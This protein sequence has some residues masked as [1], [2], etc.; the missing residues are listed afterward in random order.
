MNGTNSTHYSTLIRMA[1]L[2]MVFFTATYT[3]VEAQSCACK[4]AIQVSVDA[5]CDI[6][7]STADVLTSA[8]T[9]AGGSTITLMKTKT[10]GVI[11]DE[12]T[13]PL[14]ATIDA[15]LLIGKTIYAKVTA[16]GELNSCW[17][18]V[19]IE[20]KLKPTWW[21]TIPDTCVVTC[22]TCWQ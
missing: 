21:S 19:K 16:P 1:L 14:T 18:E 12:D 11:F 13:N 9:C 17:T 8:S 4:G 6:T 22:P 20:D 7:I 10:G 3:Q 2:V 15:S 5:L